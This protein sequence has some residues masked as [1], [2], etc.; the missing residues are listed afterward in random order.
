MYL[1][2]TLSP[3]LDPQG[4]W[5]SNNFGGMEVNMTENHPHLPQIW[6]TGQFT[7]HVDKLN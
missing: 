4:G 7:L 5:L 6:P 1:P 2:K 3:D